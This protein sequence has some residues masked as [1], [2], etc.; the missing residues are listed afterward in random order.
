M[1]LAMWH[2]NNMARACLVGG[3]MYA[4]A[5]LVGMEG[6]DGVDFGGDAW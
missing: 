1:R 6:S 2:R 3:E 5:G 4:L